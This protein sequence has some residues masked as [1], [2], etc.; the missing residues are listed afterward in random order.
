M[1]NSPYLFWFPLVESI[2]YWILEW[3]LRPNVSWDCLFGKPFSSPLL[4]GSVC[5]CCWSMFFVCSRMMDPVYVSSL[6]AYVLLLGNWVHWC[7]EILGTNDCCFLL[8]LLLE[9][10]L[11]LCFSS[12]EFAV[13]RLISCFFLGVVSHLVLNFSFYYPLWGWISGKILFKFGF[14]LGIPW[15]LHPL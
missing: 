7:W 2:F 5:L 8:F 14:C 4:W 1:K 10:E 11:R 6:L 3:L 15:F 12:F 9:L 13:K